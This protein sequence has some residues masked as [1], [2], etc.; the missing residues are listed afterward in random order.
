MFL[1]SIEVL[2]WPRNLAIIDLF[3]TV[4][5]CPCCGSGQL[6]EDYRANQRLV[7]IV[8]QAKLVGSEAVDD[9]CEGGVVSLEVGH[10]L[11]PH[12]FMSQ[13]CL[14]QFLSQYGLLPS[15]E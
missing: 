2:A 5:Y 3:E 6:L 8:V 9:L 12:L 15:F 4:E 10:S 11:S 14:Y 7:T 13:V 1:L